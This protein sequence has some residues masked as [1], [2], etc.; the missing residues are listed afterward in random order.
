MQVS[1]AKS[2]LINQLVKGAGAPQKEV[3][4]HLILKIG[5]GA[6]VL[7]RQGQESCN[8]LFEQESLVMF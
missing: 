3:L 1:G 2:S 4:F 8:I 7:M 6:V 5:I